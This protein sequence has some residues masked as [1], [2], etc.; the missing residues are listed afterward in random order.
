MRSASPVSILVAAG[1]LAG[2]S[3][4][5]RD[6]TP[7]HAKA[8]SSSESY[9]APPPPG[10]PLSVPEALRVAAEHPGGVQSCYELGMAY[11]CAGEYVNSVPRFERAIRLSPAGVNTEAY[12]YLANCYDALG[13]PKNA[14]RTYQRLNRLALQKHTRAR[15]DACLGIEYQAQS[16]LKS[17]VAYYTLSL[18][19]DAHQGA[20]LFGLGII[21]MHDG[22]QDLA[23]RYYHL[24]AKYAGAP[25]AEAKVHVNMGVIFETRGDDLGSLAEYRRALELD[26]SA[27]KAH[28]GVARI[29]GSVGD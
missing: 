25:H 5:S 2:C 17:A 12:F 10:R 21:A 19:Y 26:P 29:A 6:N 22:N 13:Q 4:P 7:P 14:V 28:E 23:L 9:Y 24:A 8:G 3:H 16:D 20:S 15:V 18:T 11:Y 27:V 1:V